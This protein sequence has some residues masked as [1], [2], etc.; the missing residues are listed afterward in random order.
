[1]QTFDWDEIC[2]IHDCLH[3]RLTLENLNAVAGMWRMVIHGDF[4]DGELHKFDIEF[5]TLRH[6]CNFYDVCENDF[7]IEFRDNPPKS[8]TDPVTLT[9]W[10]A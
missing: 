8:F 5:A 9:V 1:M 7:T 6:A 3:T 2:S 4:L 10:Q